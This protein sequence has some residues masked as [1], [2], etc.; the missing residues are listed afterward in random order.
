MEQS[1]PADLLESPRTEI[2]ESPESGRRDRHTRYVSPSL[3]ELAVQ[4]GG[5]GRVVYMGDSANFKYVLHEVGDPFQTSQ[6]HR[7]WGDN[8]QRSMLERL[9]QPAQSAIQKI[10]EDDHKHL[11]FNGAFRMPS[12]Q[13]GDALIDSFWRYSYP[14]FPLFDWSSFSL[15]YSAGSIPPLLLNAVFMVA[16]FHCPESVLHDAGF[17][18]RYLASLT[19]YRRAKALYDSDN[20]PDGI[21]IVQAT[22]LMSN[23]WGG[24]M[25]QKDTW[26]WL[27]VA[28]SLAQSL[29][30]HRS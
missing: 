1:Y 23:W 8:L 25:E 21:T 4:Q 26:Y 28:A 2:T 24:P 29:G 13:T 3:T 9:G 7:F 20:E 30:M 16:A 5:P 19:F 22:I 6:Q 17:S 14:V 18:S 27:G 12:K 11:Q 15:D 10:R